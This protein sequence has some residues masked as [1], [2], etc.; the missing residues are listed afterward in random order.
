MGVGDAVI[1]NGVGYRWVADNFGPLV[2]R[3][4]AGDD[5]GPSFVAVLGDLN[6]IAALV[7]V[8]DGRTS[9][10]ENEHIDLCQGSEHFAV[11]AVATGERQSCEEPWQAV[12]SDRKVLPASLLTKGSRQPAFA[13]A[14][15]LRISRGSLSVNEDICLSIG[16]NIDGPLKR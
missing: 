16:R 15:L 8:Q 14:G 5:G 2:D 10:V 3:H 12:I 6:E 7:S 1:E 13:D 9:I 4:L 11:S